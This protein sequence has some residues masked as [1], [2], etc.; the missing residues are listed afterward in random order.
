VIAK[1]FANWRFRTA[2]PAFAPGDEIRAHLTGFDAATGE[3]VARIGDTVLRVSG[4]DAGQVDQL[5]ALR[6]E[7]FDVASATGRAA[8]TR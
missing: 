8:L 6:V 7:S 1:L 2:R 5:V 4:V 3:G